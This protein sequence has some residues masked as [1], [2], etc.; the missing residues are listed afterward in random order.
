[1]VT[2]NGLS[3]ESP[4]EKTD[5][6]KKQRIKIQ[7]VYSAEKKQ[8]LDLQMMLE[9][10]AE[11]DKPRELVKFSH[12]E[13]APDKMSALDD[14]TEPFDQ[15]KGKST[16]YNWDIYSTTLPAESSLTKEQI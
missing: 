3:Q 11:D 9:Q 14:D 1:M 16:N 10:I 12:W 5:S 2:E 6:G 4:N 15:F 7:K 8:S 13:G